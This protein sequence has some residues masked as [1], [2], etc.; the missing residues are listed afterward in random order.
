MKPK[1]HYVIHLPD[2]LARQGALLTTFTQERKHRLVIRYTRNRAKRLNW[3]LGAVEEMTCHQVWD[4]CRPFVRKGLLQ[5][6][7][8]GARILFA[9][10]ELHPNLAGASFEVTHVGA[11]L[12]L[13]REVAWWTE[14]LRQI[15]QFV[16][17]DRLAY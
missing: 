1:H 9:L 16:L 17:L 4:L 3:E 2:I 13:S 10:Q 11:E 8:P 15:I 12:G 6:R 5:T 14:L 7:S